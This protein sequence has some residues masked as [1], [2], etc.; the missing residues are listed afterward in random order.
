MDADM[1]YSIQEDNHGNLWLLTDQGL[2][3]FSPRA[4]WGNSFKVFRKQDGPPFDKL[5]P[6]NLLKCRDGKLYFGGRRYTGDGFVR[7]H[8]D[9]LLVNKISPQVILTSFSVKNEPFPLD[10]SI[11]EIQLKYNENYFSFEFAALD[12]KDS[13][14]NQYA[15]QLQGLDDN[16]I[17][18]GNFRFASYT[19]VPPGNYTFRVKGSNNDGYWNDEGAIV[20]VTVLSPPWA[21]WWAYTLYGLVFVAAVYGLRRYDPKRQR[22]KHALDLEHVEAEKLKELDSVKSR[23]FANIS[24]EF[25]TPLTLILGPLQNLFSKVSDEPARQDLNIMQRNAQ[26]L[27][28]LINQLLDLSKLEAG[29]MELHATEENINQ[30]VGNYVQ[31]F[32]SLA[33]H[34]GIELIFKSERDDIPVFIDKDKVEKILYNL[35]SNAFKFKPERGRI[36]VAVNG[37]LEAGSG[38]REAGCR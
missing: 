30:L 24:H 36:E 3:R 33:K 2:A 32:E 11:S 29:K 8:P 34:K 31:Q 4:E 23:F 28:K 16:W 19:A 9:S 5:F 17:Y 12:Y 35:L 26:R 38:K 20:R 7:F 6:Y 1:I 14:S 37:R 22:L 27:Q 21:T 25:R 15:Y 18:S 13:M 10:S